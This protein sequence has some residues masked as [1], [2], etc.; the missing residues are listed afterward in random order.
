MRDCP[1]PLPLPAL[2]R[3]YG[4]PVTPKTPSTVD[5]EWQEASV[6]TAALWLAGAVEYADPSMVAKVRVALRYSRHRRPDDP[7]IQVTMQQVD[8]EESR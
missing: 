7:L 8:P 3:I 5:E 1:D 6:L 4:P 2:E